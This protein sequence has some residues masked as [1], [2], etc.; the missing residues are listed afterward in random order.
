MISL[1]RFYFPAH[2]WPQLSLEVSEWLSQA[3]RMGISRLPAQHRI[4]PS[5]QDTQEQNKALPPS[6]ACFA[7]PAAQ[8]ELWQEKMENIETP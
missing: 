7:V 3:Q 2:S 8:L 5:H 1:E 6:R 4:Q